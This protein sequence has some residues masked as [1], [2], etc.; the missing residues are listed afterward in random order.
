MIA[1]GCM[2]KHGRV[3]LDMADRVQDAEASVPLQTWQR[4]AYIYNAWTSLTRCAV[5]AIPATTPNARPI[6]N[7]EP[8]HWH[9]TSHTC[10]KGIG[11]SPT[12]TVPSPSTPSC[13]AP[14]APPPTSPSLSPPAATC[15][16]GALSGAVSGSASSALTLATLSWDTSWEASSCSTSRMLRRRATATITAN[17]PSSAPAKTTLL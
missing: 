5:L 14:G 17:V 2:L 1:A 10:I 4:H 6:C 7:M 9:Q 13:V 15:H 12:S 8:C 3:G 11:G 16:C